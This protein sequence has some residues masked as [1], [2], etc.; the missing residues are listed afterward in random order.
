M[1]ESEMTGWT[2]EIDET[3]CLGCGVCLSSAPDSFT[4]DDAGQAVLRQPPADSLD[5][6]QL[7][8]DSCP[9]GALRLVITPAPDPKDM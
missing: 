6:I 1:P 2:V 7:A 3:A 4:Q 9:T 5:R 8:I